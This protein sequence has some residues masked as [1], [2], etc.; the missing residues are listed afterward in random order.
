MD[1]LFWLR[2]DG[3][4]NWAETA[5]RSGMAKLMNFKLI[6]QSKGK[7]VSGFISYKSVKDKLPFPALIICCQITC[8]DYFA[9][10]KQGKE[11]KDGEL[12]HSE[13]AESML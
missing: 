7:S 12:F 11:M 4:L 10:Q 9:N 6:G 13:L 8:S 1:F 5:L 3:S 2:M